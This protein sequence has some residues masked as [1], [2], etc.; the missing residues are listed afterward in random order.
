MIVLLFV[1]Y[2]LFEN[3]SK[4]TKNSQK[5][6]KAEVSSA[7]CAGVRGRGRCCIQRHKPAE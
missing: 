6:Q 7:H 5:N 4:N 3:D 1:D 2:R